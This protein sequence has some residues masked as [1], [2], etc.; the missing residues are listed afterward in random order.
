MLFEVG[1]AGELF[2]AVLALKW[3]FTG[4]DSLMSD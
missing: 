4:M 3:F 1:S 2:V